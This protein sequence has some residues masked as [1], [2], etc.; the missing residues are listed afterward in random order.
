[1]QK[2]RKEKEDKNSLKINKH[3]FHSLPSTDTKIRYLSSSSGEFIFL[4]KTLPSGNWLLTHELSLYGGRCNEGNGGEYEKEKGR[5]CF[6]CGNYGKY[7]KTGG[8]LKEEIFFCSVGC[9]KK[10]NDEFELK[11]KNI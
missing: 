3:V 11:S 10:I 9:S 6:N 8:R 1:M 2:Q 7:K 5:K 4:D